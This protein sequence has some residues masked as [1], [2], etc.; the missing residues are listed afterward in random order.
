MHFYVFLSVVASLGSAL[1]IPDQEILTTISKAFPGLQEYDYSQSFF[2]GAGNQDDEPDVE[3]WWRMVSAIARDRRDSAADLLLSLLRLDSTLNGAVN[4][5]KYRNLGGGGTDDDRDDGD[6]DGDDRDDSE[7]DER[8]DS[9]YRTGPGETPGLR[10]LRHPRP[11]Y[12]RPFPGD[13]RRA[14]PPEVFCPED[15]T[16]W[17]LI[18]E[19]PKT[20]RLANLI[21]N[22]DHLI[23]VLNSTAATHTLFAPTNRALERLLNEEPPTQILKQIEHYHVIPGLF[24]TDKLRL[25]QTL[26]TALNES[27][28]GKQMPQRVVVDKRRNGLVLNGRSRIVAGDIVSQAPKPAKNQILTKFSSRTTVSSTKSTSLSY[29]LQTQVRLSIFSQP[30][31]ALSPMA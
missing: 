17:E 12:G 3:P 1:V 18:N 20:S 16:I 19:S 11:G 5:S 2:T 28:L 7:D 24:N 14:C 13:D 22:N 15:H 21:K 30:I 8:P 23:N 10:Y 27:S 9:R 26:R 29:H 6:D 4:L 25:H 31:S